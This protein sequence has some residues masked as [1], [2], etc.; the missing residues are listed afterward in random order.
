[1]AFL[2]FRDCEMTDAHVGTVLH[3]ADKTS[4]EGSETTRDDY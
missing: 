1:M 4:A 3:L 2:T